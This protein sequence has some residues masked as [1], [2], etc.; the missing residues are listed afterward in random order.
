[1]RIND[2]IIKLQIWD[3]S[4]VEIYSSLIGNFYGS[5][6]LII[7]LYSIDNQKS[8]DDIKIW[9]KESKKENPEDKIFL[10]GN[11]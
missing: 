3:T 9:L 6:S 11:K 10:V 1:M 8:F 7:I 5:S 2:K 4:S